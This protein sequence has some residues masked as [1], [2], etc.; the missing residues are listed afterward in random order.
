MGAEVDSSELNCLAP[1]PRLLRTA[2][3]VNAQ[4]D[5]LDK[6]PQQV[7]GLC[8][9]L[10]ALQKQCEALQSRAASARRTLT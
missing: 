4:L 3:G 10:R 8:E 2:S 6:L 1:A 7:A 5:T 9:Q